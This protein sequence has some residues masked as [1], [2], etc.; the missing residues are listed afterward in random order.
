VSV[1]L[2]AAL[3]L[4]DDARAALAGWARSL[5]PDPAV[6]LVP[7]ENLHVTLVFLGAQDEGDVEA[8]ADAVC[9]AA[10]PLG[11]LA[12]VGA[13]WLPNPRRPGVLVADLAAPDE[14]AA[15]HRDLVAALRPWHE[16]ESRPLRP[17]VTVARV[18]RGQRPA[19]PEIPAHPA[20]SFS[21]TGLVLYRSRVGSAGAVYEPLAWAAL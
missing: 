16:P 19:S 7:E 14:L 9:S 21:A 13:A 17:H 8:I 5:P 2:F 15:L 4:P 6:R 10:R 3:A 11:A 12:V 20:V 1:R 18:R